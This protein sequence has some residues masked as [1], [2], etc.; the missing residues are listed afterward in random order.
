[1]NNCL[2]GGMKKLHAECLEPCGR[3]VCGVAVA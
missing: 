2:T 1:M 3:S